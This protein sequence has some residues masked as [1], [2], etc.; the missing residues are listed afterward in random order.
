MIQNDNM[1][2]MNIESKEVI[3][4]SGIEKSNDKEYFYDKNYEYEEN[5][6]KENDNYDNNYKYDKNKFLV[7]LTNTEKAVCLQEIIKKLKKILYV[8]DKSLEPNSNYNYKVYCGGVLIYISSSNL[9]FDGE[10]VNI[11][12]NINAILT[13]NF[14]KTQ[15]KKIVFE[16]INYAQYL[17]SNYN[18]CKDNQNA[19]DIED[20][21]GD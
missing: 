7:T 10:L 15:I 14:S 6:N 8:Y 2:I 21:A 3:Y 4:M 18:Q 19:Q 1:N 20:K 5:L 13:N 12:V 16:S 9:L 17:L 11:V